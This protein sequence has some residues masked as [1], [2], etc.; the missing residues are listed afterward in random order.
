MRVLSRRFRCASGLT[1]C[2]VLLLA[3]LPGALAGPVPARGSGPT[4][5]RSPAVVAGPQQYNANLNFTVVVPAAV[6][7]MGVEFGSTYEIVVPTFPSSGP[8]QS[9]V[10]P[11]AIVRFPSTV[12]Y[13]Q[14]I[15]PAVNVTIQNN[16][17]V[18]VP[19]GPLI[20][21][22]AGRS[23]AVNQTASLS[24]QGLAVTA[25][26][27]P[28][29]Y[30]TDVRWQ[31]LEVNPDGGRT[32]GSWSAWQQVDPAQVLTVVGALP[33]IITEGVP[34]AIC[35]SGPIGG[36]S[37][38]VHLSVGA[39][40]TQLA[41]GV[42]DVPVGAVAPFCFNNTLAV[43]VAPQAAYIHLWEEGTT[44]YLHFVSKVNVEDPSAPA[45]SGSL[46]ASPSMDGM[47]L[48]PLVAVVVILAAVLAVFLWVRRPPSA[49]GESFPSG[50][51]LPPPPSPSAPPSSDDWPYAV[52]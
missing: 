26:W 37:F 44:P 6:L 46:P 36:R 29:M 15:L 41:L 35:L 1:V 19:V 43:P 52:R 33:K 47:P 30:P 34:Y 12:G 38:A 49:P 40:G 2:I 24:T 7:P 45:P 23:I 16:G 22:A 42:A 9:V 48:L 3:S 28:G 10:V 21:E 8:P 17:T 18:V 27:S 5:P 13:S 14:L 4:A 31:W 32:N 51:P 11:S 50:L 39:N 20:R 25:T